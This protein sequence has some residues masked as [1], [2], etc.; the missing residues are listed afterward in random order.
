[1]KKFL[2]VI[3]SLIMAFSLAAPA[4]A[5]APAHHTPVVILRGD[6]VELSRYDE[7]GNAIEEVYPISGDSFG[8][9]IGETA[10]NILI[11]FLTEGLLFDKWDNY[12]QVCYEELSPILGDIIMDDN[13]D[14]ANGVGLAD[15]RVRENLTSPNQDTSAW[16]DHL[17]SATDYTFYYDWRLDPDAVIGELH[18]YITKVYN[19]TGRPITLA[20]NCLGG[21]YVLAYLEE[22]IERD[23]HM[24]KNVF[25]NSTTGNSTSILTDVFCGDIEINAKALQRFADEYIDSDSDMI[26]NMLDTVPEIND[27]IL[28]TI[29]LLVSLGIID[30]LGLAIDDIYD[31]VYEV[32]VPMLVIAFYGTMPGYW[33]MI[34]PERFEEAK[35]FVFGEK[36]SEYRIQYAGLIEKIDRYYNEVSSRKLEIIE[37]CKAKGIY[38]GATAKYG[39]QMLPFVE[40]QYQLSDEQVD[41]YHASFGATTAKDVYSVLP[42][43]HIQKAIAD[44]KGD[45]I[46]PDK[47]IDA[48][49]S[50]FP[51]TVWYEKNVSHNNWTTDY[52]IIEAFSR[53]ENFNVYSDPSL[54]RYMILIPGTEKIDDDGELNANLS[55]VVPMTE[56]NCHLTLWDDTPEDA[57]DEE[58]T[59]F[60]RLMSFFRWL[61]AMLRFILRISQDNPGSLEDFEG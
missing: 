56:E 15:Y 16:G 14:P 54:P 17:Y 7:N 30:M 50:L 18:D 6:G 26:T 59:V 60:S 29:D 27:V 39:V 37:T 22:Y 45:Y 53:N 43:E 24:I 33:T 31:R 19:A 52:A 35:N 46:S 5:V 38:F 28:T 13:G 3:L 61:T 11:P 9:K 1:M 2:C 58:E 21:S 47:Q 42:D 12:Y 25:F 44:G 23:S 41:L 32:L 55:D 8:D 36:G 4:L 51:N 10:I 48:S 20:G 34:E 57:K 49:T 40:S